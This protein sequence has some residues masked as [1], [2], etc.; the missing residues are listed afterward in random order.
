[1]SS[2]ASTD[3]KRSR[4]SAARTFDVALDMPIDPNEPTYCLCSR[5]A[6]GEMVGCDNP[7][8]TREWFHFECVG[9]AS[10]PKGK[11]YCPECTVKRKL[12]EK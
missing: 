3:N 7:D 12:L 10:Q 11:W 5:V 9:L 8:C 6:F 1:M 2:A 4:S